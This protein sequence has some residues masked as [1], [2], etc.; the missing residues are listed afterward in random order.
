[1]ADEPYASTKEANLPPLVS[2]LLTPSYSRPGSIQNE[3]GMRPKSSQ[4]KVS[5]SRGSNKVASYDDDP[6]SL[7]AEYFPD[8]M[9][10]L[11]TPPSSSKMRVARKR[12]PD[13]SS[14]SLSQ[15]Q[16]PQPHLHKA[17]NDRAPRRREVEQEREQGIVMLLS[18]TPSGGLS[19]PIRHNNGRGKVKGA[20]STITGGVKV[21]ASSKKCVDPSN[22]SASSRFLFDDSSNQSGDS[23]A[24]L[25]SDFLDS[26][27][28]VSHMLHRA[29]Q[30]SGAIPDAEVDSTSVTRKQE[31]VR[32]SARWICA[33]CCAKQSATQI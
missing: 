17:L 13:E 30:V 8:T 27:H 24:P 25:S 2:L 26:F 31:Q 6:E 7:L 10:P 14:P 29:T 19:T 1:M 33:G 9:G 5:W 23:G 22:K 21:K 20:K 16:S 28:F 15:S 3:S 18:K 4:Q 11:F 32:V 12:A